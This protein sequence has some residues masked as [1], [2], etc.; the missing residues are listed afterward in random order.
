[1]NKEAFLSL[2]APVEPVDVPE[3]TTTV[4]LRVMSAAERIAWASAKDAGEASSVMP[5]ARLLA[6]CL[7]DEA[8]NRIFDD[9]DGDAA[10]IAAKDGTVVDRLGQRALRM[11]GLSDDGREDA[12]KNSDAGAPS[13]SPSSSPAT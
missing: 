2:R 8:G 10:A 9:S 13:G 12:R 5:M 1:M 6:R 11:N 4:H 3:W 7:S